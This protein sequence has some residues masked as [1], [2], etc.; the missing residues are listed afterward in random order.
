MRGRQLQA[1]YGFQKLGRMRVHFQ[2][3]QHS[4][5]LAPRDLLQS[6]AGLVEH[7][8]GVLPGILCGDSCEMCH[9]DLP[10]HVR[11]GLIRHYNDGT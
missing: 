5:R 6:L 9:L 11:L 1:R 7:E 3:L 8:L 4:L 2:W 10:R